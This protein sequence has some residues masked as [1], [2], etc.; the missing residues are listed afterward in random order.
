MP[1]IFK[2]MYSVILYLTDIHIKW[3]WKRGEGVASFFHDS[4]EIENQYEEKK[5][6]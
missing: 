2:Y 4:E 1:Y 6:K 5:K 3:L